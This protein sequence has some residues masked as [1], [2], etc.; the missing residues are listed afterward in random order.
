MGLCCLVG[1]VYIITIF[2]EI[3]DVRQ[4]FSTS[5]VDST[6]V[7]PPLL[8]FVV[9]QAFIYGGQVTAEYLPDQPGGV[10]QPKH[11]QQALAGY[12][13]KILH[14]LNLLIRIKDCLQYPVRIQF[15]FRRE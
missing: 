13:S 15:H 3:S 14:F 7:W 4:K 8:P 10:G 11:I 2:K 5:L 9:N 12:N 6:Q 1:L